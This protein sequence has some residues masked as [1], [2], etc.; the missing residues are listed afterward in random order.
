VIQCLAQKVA[1][2]RGGG[3]SAPRAQAQI[4]RARGGGAHH[5]ANCAGGA[6]QQPPTN[7]RRDRGVPAKASAARPRR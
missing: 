7:R 3:T 4:H 5:R 2:D 6:R 1:V